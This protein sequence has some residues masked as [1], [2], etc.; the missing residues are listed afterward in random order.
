MDLL[1]YVQYEKIK[2]ETTP[3][4]L[5]NEVGVVIIQKCCYKIRYNR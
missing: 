1:R 5:K 4:Y 2:E 3:T